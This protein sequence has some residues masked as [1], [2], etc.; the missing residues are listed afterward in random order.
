MPRMHRPLTGKSQYVPKTESGKSYQAVIDLK[1]DAISCQRAIARCKRRMEECR[2]A[3]VAFTE[4]AQELK[5][6]ER[7]LA[8]LQLE[9]KNAWL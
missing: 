1:Q 9:A 5:Q 3:S 4:L 2:H 6:E 7:R 8:E